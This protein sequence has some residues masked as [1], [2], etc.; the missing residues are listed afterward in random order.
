VLPLL[1][2]LTLAAG[3]PFP[4]RAEDSRHLDLEQLYHDDKPDEGVKKTRARLK[5]HPEDAELYVL[6]ARF[7]YEVGERHKRDAAFDKEALYLEM[8]EL[9]DKA[10]EL[11]PGDP[12]IGWGLGVAKARLSTT[13]GVLASLRSAKEIETLWLTAA[14][15]GTKYRSLGGE[16]ELPCDAYLTLGIFYRLVPDWFF[17]RWIAG[18]R[19]DIKKSLRWLEKADRCSPGK[20]R[21]LKEL[22]VGQ[23]CYAD[24]RDDAVQ[25]QKGQATLRRL[26]KMKAPQET[27]R[28]DQ[29]HARWLLNHPNEACSYSRDGQQDLDKAKAPRR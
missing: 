29:A 16:E 17:I 1:L 8:I 28:I 19:G 6:L 13:R 11:R 2:S 21:V 22:A 18:T 4:E 26:L 9:L 10:R 23:L 12:R 5:A 20:I 3:V 24:R 14:R 15:A 25:A 7:L 27:D